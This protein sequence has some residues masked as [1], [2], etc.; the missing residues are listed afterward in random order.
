M[1][2]G[3]GRVA[4]NLVVL[5]ETREDW[6]IRDDVDFNLSTDYT[7]QGLGIETSVAAVDLREASQPWREGNGEQGNHS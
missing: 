2:C 1:P 7:L 4:D 5:V 3:V 6:L